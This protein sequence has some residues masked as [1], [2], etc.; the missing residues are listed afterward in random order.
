MCRKESFFFFFFFFFFF[1]LAVGQSSKQVF[2]PVISLG[3]VTDAN[4]TDL[5]KIG[6]F[7]SSRVYSMAWLAPHRPLGRSP[8]TDKKIVG[9]SLIFG[10]YSYRRIQQ[11][12]DAK[13]RSPEKFH[14]FWHQDLYK[15]LQIT[16]KSSRW[17]SFL[18]SLL[19]LVP[20]II[21]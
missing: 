5:L 13:W 7:S 4:L 1:R 11:G 20:K 10:N 8:C 16:P 2:A 18:I 15:E 9:I 12:L 3:N 14:C 17:R 6:S 19:V 21:V